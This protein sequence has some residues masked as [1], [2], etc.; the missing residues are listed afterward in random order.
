MTANPASDE[1]ASKDEFFKRL[2]DLSQE[3][4]AAHGEDFTMGALILGARY[5]A[6]KK[7]K[8]AEV[9]GK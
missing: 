9:A 6:E 5:I 3:M 4:I 2:A 1:E 8:P 7:A